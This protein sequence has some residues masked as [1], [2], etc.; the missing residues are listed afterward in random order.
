[1]AQRQNKSL[2][3]KAD[4]AGERVAETA[5]STFESARERIASQLDAVARALETATYNLQ[6]A[7][8][9]DL[10]ERAQPLIRKAEN[11]AQYLRNKTPRELKD[12]LDGFARQ[13]PAWFLGGAFVLGLLGARFLKSSEQPLPVSP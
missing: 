10:S 12:D 8:H 5:Q 7:E 13:R 3:Q 2:E 6:Q 11:A 1:M 4:E 9:A